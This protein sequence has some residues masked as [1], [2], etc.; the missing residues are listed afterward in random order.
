M[1]VFSIFNNALFSYSFVLLIE[2]CLVYP[3]TLVPSGFGQIHETCGLLIHLIIHDTLYNE[4]SP[5]KCADHNTTG[6]LNN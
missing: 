1:Y 5:T 4:S 6:L 3:V 2:S